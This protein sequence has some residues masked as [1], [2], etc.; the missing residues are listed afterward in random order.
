MFQ[1]DSQSNLKT[2]CNVTIPAMYKGPPDIAN[3]GYV[4][5]LL[6]KYMDGAVN[7]TI[8]RPTPLDRELQIRSNGNGSY[9]LMDGD[10]IIIQAKPGIIDLTVPDAPSY[11]EAVKAA[12]KSIALKPTPYTHV[13]GQG[14]HP[15]CFGCGADVPDGEGLKIHPGRIP[16]TN[17]VA[18]P[19]TP[20][21]EYGDAR[22][23]VRPEFIWTALDCPG[24]FALWE[25][26]NT[27][28]GLLGRLIGEIVKPLRCNEPCVVVAWLVGNDGRKLYAGTALFNAEGQVIGRSL[29][30]WIAMPPEFIRSDAS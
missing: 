22:G 23:Y 16:G 21:S 20:P 28:P 7:V 17:M 25:L 29:A 14:I 2:I 5:S 27:K 4:C 1:K 3:G 13:T 9:Y 10:Q 26:S 24:A 8:K 12:E 6:A 18:A 15:I 30:T 11:E 19:W